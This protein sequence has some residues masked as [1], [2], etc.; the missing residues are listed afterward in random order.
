[1]EIATLIPDD[2]PSVEDF[3]VNR[4]IEINELLSD[5]DQLSKSSFRSRS[6]DTNLVFVTLRAI[7]K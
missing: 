3:N 6:I 2:G 4:Q 7:K 5:S 1:M